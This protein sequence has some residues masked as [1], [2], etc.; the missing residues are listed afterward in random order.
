MEA[1]EMRFMVKSLLQLECSAIPDSLSIVD[2]V[3]LERIARVQVRKIF[4]V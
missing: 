3:R 4:L 1:F 2:K